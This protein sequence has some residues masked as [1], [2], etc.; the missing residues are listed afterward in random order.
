MRE[1]ISEPPGRHAARPDHQTTRPGHHTL[2]VRLFRLVAGTSYG[3]GSRLADLPRVTA[4]KV[5]RLSSPP[6]PRE[7]P[8]VR[9]G[10]EQSKVGESRGTTSSDSICRCQK[11]VR[12]GVLCERPRNG[13]E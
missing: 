2:H 4:A 8:V 11:P 7:H 12:T 6:W 9:I 3:M 5:R 13:S 10:G 1:G